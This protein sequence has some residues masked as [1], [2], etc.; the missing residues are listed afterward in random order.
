MKPPLTF[1]VV[2]FSIFIFAMISILTQY[3]VKKQSLN[4]NHRQIMFYINKIEDFKKELKN[5][6]DEAM[7]KADLAAFTEMNFYQSEI[8]KLYIE[9]EFEL[10]NGY[11]RIFPDYLFLI[12][13]VWLSY[14]LE[15]IRKKVYEQSEEKKT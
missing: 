6:P 9:N 12:F 14:Q 1:I 15:N 5:N 4:L 11:P 3:S 2:C 13:I 10:S 8:N 7:T